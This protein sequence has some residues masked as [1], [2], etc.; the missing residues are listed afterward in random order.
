MIVIATAP[1]MVTIHLACH[2][3][4]NLSFQDRLATLDGSTIVAKSYLEKRAT[5]TFVRPFLAFDYSTDTASF[6]RS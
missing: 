3:T 5:R 2:P 4:R 6:A 1:A